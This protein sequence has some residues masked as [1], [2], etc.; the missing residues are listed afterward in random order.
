MGCAAAL[1]AAAHTHLEIRLRDGRL[2]LELYDFEAGSFDPATTPIL[3][4][5]PARR[6]NPPALTNLLGDAPAVWILPQN[7]DPRLVFLGIGAESIPRSALTGG[8]LMLELTA[9]EGPGGFVVFQTLP[10][11]EPKLM[12]SSRDSL[13]DVLAL[14]AG[15]GTHVHFTWAFTAPGT[16]RATSPARGPLAATGAPADSPETVFTFVVPPPAAPRLAINHHSLLLPAGL[17][18]PV[19]VETAAEPTG[20]AEVTTLQ[21]DGRPLALPWPADGEPFRAFR[22]RLP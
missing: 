21:A 20:W 1:S 7:E 9:V 22:L 15:P 18:G 3:V 16:Y 6:A 14:R 12:F 5:P 10:F 2:A 19:I 13:P 8:N 11:G 4:G 17:Y